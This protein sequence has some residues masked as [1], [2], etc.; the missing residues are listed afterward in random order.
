MIRWFANNDIAANF[1]MAGILLTG[2]YTAF[3]RIPLEVSPQ[4]TFDGI[5]FS[6]AYR[7]GTAK[8]VERAILIPVEEA[9][10]GLN[11]VKMINADGYRG[12]ARIWIEAEPGYDLRI[13]LEDIQS[14]VDGITTFP[15][16]TERPEIR[17][18]DSTHFYDVLSVA[19]TGRLGSHELRGVAR[20]VQEDLLEIDGISLVDLSGTRNYEIAIE[21][22]PERLQSYNI[23]LGELA[24]AVR[25]SSIDLPAGSI[26]SQSGNLVVR[27]RGQAYSREEFERIPLRAS[28][29]AEVRLGEVAT[30]IDGFEEGDK[31]VEFNGKPAL[32]VEI[33]RT[34]NES[35]IDV[36]N[37]VTEYVRTSASRFPDGIEL[38]IFDDESIS[39]RGRLNALTSSLLQGSLLVFLVLGLFLRPQLAFWVVVGIPVCFAGGVM[40][41]PTF[42]VTANVMSIFGFIIVVG[43]VVDDAIVTGENIYSKM[44]Q[45][46]DPLEASITG[47]REVAVPVTFGVLTTVVAFLPLMFFEGRWGSFAKQ[48]PPVVG[49]VLLFSL[50]ESK[51][52]LPAH[53]KHLKT[54]VVGRNPFLRIQQRL[55]DGLERF[56]ERIYQPLLEYSV[57]HRGVVMAVFAASALAMAGYCQGGRLGFQSLPSVDRLKVSAYLGLP[58]DA[59]IE[60]THRCV[61][62]IVTAAEK[63]R[64]EFVDQGTGKSLIKSIL[65]VSGA[66]HIS[67]SYNKSRAYVAVEVVPPSVRSEPGPRNSVIANRWTELVGPIPEATYF[68]IRGEESRGRDEDRETEALELELRGPSS[69]IKNAI[70]ERIADELKAFE[71]INNAQAEVNHGQDELEFTLKPRAAELGL[72]QQMLAQQIRRAFFGEEAQ[73]LMR[74]VDDIR[75]M[76]RLPQQERESLH[77]IDRLKIR[78]PDGGSEVPLATVADLT[79]VQAP[80]SIE[81]NAGAEIIRIGAQPVDENVDIIGIAREITP[82]LQE[83]C[84]EG[85]DLSFVFTGYVAEAAESRKR[86][87]VGSIALF[88]AL[89]ALLAIPFKSMIQPFYV[90]IAVPFGVIGALLGHVVMGITPSYLS[91]FGMLAL[92]GVV[93]NDSLVL[94]DFVNRQ[95]REGMPLREAVL[96]AGGRRFR[97]ILLTSVT[98]FVGLI[99][100][101]MDRS[102]QAQFLIPMAVSLGFG[103]LFATAITLILVPCSLL[104]GQD[105]GRLLAQ[106]REWYLGPFR[107][108]EVRVPHP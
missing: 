12:R 72:T 15:N 24:N 8:D 14:R 46:M 10:E 99:P 29:G 68:R 80:S 49:P 16:E 40:L 73:R 79:F 62:R 57:R 69:E 75:V 103:V 22:D 98:T 7:G 11:G 104:V 106:V 53:L 51:L 35:A 19:V 105:I 58:N 1:L 52:I 9:L 4:R 59:T 37:K 30:V 63:L 23:G 44:R 39:I 60:N 78:T 74:G 18:P 32:F 91:V 90:L 27:T 87:I 21:A 94:M 26:Q 88:F 96:I 20:R 97:P 41:M 77:T 93:V 102:I 2:V 101:L 38:F 84:N 82:R 67:S 64:G 66:R 31:V 95:V 5:Y 76:V 85:E 92:A 70:A 34:G 33:M 89:F 81:R 83:I 17:I 108:S 47:A 86:T 50:V 13:L 42:G 28:N 71:G 100:L 54:G 61:D 6:M 56:V 36:S 107:A 65:T 3:F 48:I 55:A 43:V 25:R 45:G